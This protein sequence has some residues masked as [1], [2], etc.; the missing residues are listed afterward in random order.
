MRS[1]IVRFYK[2]DK[3][4]WEN[5]KFVGLDKTRIENEVRAYSLNHSLHFDL[6][7]NF[8]KLDLYSLDGALVHSFLNLG[9]TKH[10]IGPLSN[11]VYLYKLMYANGF[12]ISCG[13][14]V[15]H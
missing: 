6:P 9:I 8:Y 10:R 14:L 15:V 11:G 13:K 5:P 4:L 12:S 3:L 2:G 7:N 1:L